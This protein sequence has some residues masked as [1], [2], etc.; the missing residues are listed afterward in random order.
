MRWL[1]EPGGNFLMPELIDRNTHDGWT[2]CG[3]V[4]RWRPPID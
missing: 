1:S 4:S 2:A 3:K